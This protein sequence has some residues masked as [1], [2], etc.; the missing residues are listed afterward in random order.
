MSEHKIETVRVHLVTVPTRTVHS[1]GSGDVGAIRSVLLE[2]VTDTGLTGWGEAS[3]WPVFTGTVEANA[4]AMHGYFAPYLRGRDPVQV[5]VLMNAVE[6]ILVG[7]HEAKAALECALLDLTGQICGLSIAE[8]VGGRHREAIPLSFS[9]ANPDF[10]KDLEDIAAMWADGVRLFKLKTGFAGH[11]F[12]LMRLEKLRAVYGDEIDLRI[13]YNQ[14]LPAFDAIRHVRDLEPFRPTF[15][16]Q[17]VKRH[18]REALAA[19]TR[20]VDVPI[21][22]DES[23]FD[24]REALLGAQM[25]L[26]DVFSLKIMKSAGIRRAL[27]VAAIARAAGI[28]VYGGCMFETSIAHAAGAQLMAA[29]PDLRLGCEFYMSTYYAADDIAQDPFPVKGGLVH[30]PNG[31]GLGVRPDAEKLARYRSDLLI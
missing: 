8:L 27:E 20:S 2:L 12:D 22:A 11:S 25:R 3:P 19:I 4:A 18:E 16:E 26:S 7:H 24:P 10:G 21:M 23:V 15:V 5:E 9:V 13:D 1:H 31:P 6:K 29:V 30:V 14:G 17:P 28:E